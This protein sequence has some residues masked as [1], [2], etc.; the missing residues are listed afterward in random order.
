[1]ATL[2]LIDGEKGGVG[3]SWFATCLS[4]YLM[5]READFHLVETDR[6][7][8]TTANRYKGKEHYKPF[9][10][11]CLRY[12][13]FSEDETQIQEA[14]KVMLLAHEKPT[15]VV[16][17]SQAHRA[18]VKWVEKYQLLESVESLGVDLL[19]WF[20]CDGENDSIHL[21]IKSIEH[22][23]DQVPHV[24]VRNFGRCDNWT[25]FDKHQQVQEVI[26][27]YNVTVIDFPKL[28]DY[29]RIALNA[30]R[31]TLEDALQSADF[32][33]MDKQDITVYRKKVF[34]VLESTGLL[35]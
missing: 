23:K 20:I 2:H 11:K 17:P 34:A 33:I 32:N 12:A 8:P 15:F 21:A 5:D 7:N 28:T 22:Y 25:Y 27:T 30:K 31:M 24:L 3:K 6:S 35:P 16:L 13:Y 10:S 14:D 4:E 26:K 1:M 19:K 9:I 18:V 29:R